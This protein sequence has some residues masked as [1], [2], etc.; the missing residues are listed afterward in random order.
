MK[1]RVYVLL[2]ARLNMSIW[3]LDVFFFWDKEACDN[4]NNSF[5]VFIQAAKLTH[6][7]EKHDFEIK[8]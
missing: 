4:N 1:H 7:K 6:H 3:D 2:T 8:F 5:I